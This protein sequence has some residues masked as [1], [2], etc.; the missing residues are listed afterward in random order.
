[1][2]LPY[3]VVFQVSTNG[4]ITFGEA[5]ND[6][7]AQL[8]PPLLW[9]YT[10]APFWQNFNTTVE[11]RVLWSII[12]KTNNSDYVNMVNRLIQEEQGDTDFDGF[13]MLV[14]SWE[15]VLVEGDSVRKLSHSL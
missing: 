4:L 13:W 3:F 6:F 5:A 12:D 7:P 11:G 14:A 1:M 15:D 8:F 10:V 9:E 2:R